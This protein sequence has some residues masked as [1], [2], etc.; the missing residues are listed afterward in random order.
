MKSHDEV[1]RARN[2]FLAYREDE[3]RQS[4]ARS[5]HIEF[6]CDFCENLKLL[7]D[8]CILRIDI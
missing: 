8:N 1:G 5:S 7:P 6:Q 4:Q 3:T 2:I